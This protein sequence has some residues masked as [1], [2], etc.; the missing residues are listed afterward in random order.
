M[1]ASARTGAESAGD[2][3][4]DSAGEAAAADGEA[5]C[6]PA[7]EAEGD[8][9]AAEEVAAWQRFVGDHPKLSQLDIRLAHL[10][11]QETEQLSM[12]QTAVLLD[13]HRAMAVQ[14]EEVRDE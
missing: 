2:S 12:E 6:A 4:G 10:L 14:L 1:G 7:A 5:L 8:E 13:V 3:A 9:G 11:G